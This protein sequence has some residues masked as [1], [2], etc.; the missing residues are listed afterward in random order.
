MFLR[1]ELEATTRCHNPEDVYLI[2][3]VK[4]LTD[5]FLSY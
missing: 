3:D 2:A 4:Y 5:D 1:K